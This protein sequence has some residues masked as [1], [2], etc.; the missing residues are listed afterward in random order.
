M[1]TQEFRRKRERLA[2]DS[3]RLGKITTTRS[4]PNS[5]Q[6]YWE[7]G[8]AWKDWNRRSVELLERK[9][10]LEARKKRSTN[11]KRAATKKSNATSSTSVS[12]MDGESSAWSSGTLSGA[13]LDAELD[14]IT[15][16]EVLKAH[17]EQYKR[18]ETALNEERRL[19]ESEKAV[20]QKVNLT[21]TTSKA[22]SKLA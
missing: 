5:C 7:D 3:V 15:E 13:E 2:L 9:E 8:Y 11:M 4:G 12:E 22:P 10:E 20:H 17:F 6:D 14:I 19:L 1:A 16:A 18:D 21:L